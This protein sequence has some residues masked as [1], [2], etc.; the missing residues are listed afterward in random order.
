MPKVGQKKAPVMV[1]PEPE[2]VAPAV[3]TEALGPDQ[4]P[5]L[6]VIY[7]ELECLE[8]SSVSENGPVTPDDLKA[9]FNWKTEEQW[10][11]EMMA[12]HPE[13]KPEAWLFYDDFHCLDTDGNKVRCLNNAGNRPFDMEWCKKLIHNILHGEWAGPHT[14]EGEREE[15][16][17]GAE[18]YTMRDG[19]VLQP[20]DTFTAK[21]ASIN[22]EAIRISKYGRWLSGQHQGTALILSQE[23]LLKSRQAIYY[24]PNDPLTE[25]YPKWR[26]HSHVFIETYVVTGLSEDPR[27]LRT[28]DY[29]KPRSAAD[30]L[31]TMDL[32]K[33]N[34][35]SER[36]EMTR[37]LASG[38][39]MLWT[40]TDAKGYRTHPEIVGFLERHLKMLECVEH[41]FLENK[42]QDVGSKKRR[43]GESE[44]QHQV[45][46]QIQ[47]AQGGRRISK[48]R[49]SP[50][51][52]SALCFLMG[53]SATSEATSESYRNMNPPTQDVLD[54][55]LLE[56]AK[57][58]WSALA[59]D[60]KFKP[61][62]TAL[63]RLVE[64]SA[65]GEEN[66]GQGLGGRAEEKL[67]ILAQAWKVF[68]DHNDPDGDN[69][70]FP[71]TINTETMELES[72]D[73]IAPDG[74][75]SLCYTD[76]DDKGNKLPEG[77]I[78]LVNVAD[79]RG[80]DC[81]AISK[82]KSAQQATAPPAPPPETEEELQARIAAERPKAQERAMAEKK[83]GT[84][85]R[86]RPITR[87]P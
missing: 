83:S 1:L 3:A 9:L 69:P 42:P 2:K 66:D 86:V 71:Y 44:E 85:G 4:G 65:A 25:K 45:R 87:K 17:G 8:Y 53:S 74:A 78:K 16:Y 34:N 32:F 64:T 24:D 61:V 38:V 37:M 21:V 82:S 84:G 23:L 39:D 55:S 18:P 26:G 11:A 12:A 59:G 68:H 81:Y 13:S 51:D 75:L 35:P 58:F 27:V 54:W 5:G 77:K 28:I 76:K 72:D 15:V 50:G 47:A 79:F 43:D 19:T 70:P 41:L 56:R 29:V 14:I 73:L 63:N 30:M 57:A 62:R 40:R 31:Y 46:L 36:K 33:K 80:I 67:A 20:G 48:L 22:G 52:A 7:P 60:S 6:P 49:L 10:K